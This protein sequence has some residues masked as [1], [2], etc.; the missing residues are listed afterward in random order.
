MILPNEEV[1]DKSDSCQNK[2][3]GI[4]YG[5]GFGEVVSAC[6]LPTYAF[7]LLFEGDFFFHENSE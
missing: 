2:E 4:E 5:P 6:P 1:H 7:H 3:Q